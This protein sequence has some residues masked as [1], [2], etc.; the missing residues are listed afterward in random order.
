[1]A[2]IG[3]C[4]LGQKFER[5]RPAQS[6]FRLEEDGVCMQHSTLRDDTFH[7][8]A[9][10]VPPLSQSPPGK[11]SSELPFPGETDRKPF[12]QPGEG[13]LSGSVKGGERSVG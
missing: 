1:M 7:T 2:G 5:R 12:S 6:T 4:R 3:L 8:R 11:Q 13:Q 10:S 9:A